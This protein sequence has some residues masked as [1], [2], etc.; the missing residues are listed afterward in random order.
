MF[1]KPG[2]YP[3]SLAVRNAF[4]LKLNII[5]A[6][7]LYY[8]S[9]PV[10]QAVRW[11]SVDGHSVNCHV[12]RMLLACHLCCNV[13]NVDTYVDCRLRRIVANYSLSDVLSNSYCTSHSYK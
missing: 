10:T 2:A 1:P 8:K 11:L 12:G 9:L 6:Y 13:M 4:K 5:V 7:V 3:S